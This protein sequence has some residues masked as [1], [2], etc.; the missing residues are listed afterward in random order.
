MAVYGLKAMFYLLNHE[1]LKI[2][3]CCQKGKQ[4]SV[5]NY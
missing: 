2:A 4:I 3:N 1:T 5:N